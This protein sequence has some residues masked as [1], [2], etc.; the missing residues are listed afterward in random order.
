MTGARSEAASVFPTD[1]GQDK[2]LQYEKLGTYWSITPGSGP[3]GVV[4]G[5]L[6]NDSGR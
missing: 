1:A 4:T 6:A 5:G 3:M 2:L